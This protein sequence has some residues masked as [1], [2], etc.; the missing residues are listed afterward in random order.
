MEN[1]RQW[2][3]A[4]QLRRFGDEE[5]AYLKQVLDK[6]ALSIFDVEN[7]M[8]EQFEKAF[9]RYT[10]AKGAQAKGNAMAGLAE[11]VS[12]SGAG[13]GTEVICDPIVHFG[14]LATVYFNAV[15]RFA[16]INASNL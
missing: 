3:V 13:V 10:G 6:G 12:I 4:K 15:P 7:G 9:A 11:A 5:L 2:E 16:D 8:V 1:K 14:A